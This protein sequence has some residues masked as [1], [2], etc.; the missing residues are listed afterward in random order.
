MDVADMTGKTVIVTG[1]NSGIGLETDGAGIA[2]K[3]F[4]D[5][6][7]ISAADAPPDGPGD[8]RQAAARIVGAFRA[9]GKRVY[10]ADFTTPDVRQL[11]LSVQRVWSPDLIA[12]PLPSAPPL[13]HPRF[14][15]YGG[16]ARDDPHPY[17]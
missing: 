5:C 9:A 16:V 4:A 10:H 8:P 11:G 17:P 14:A 2:E 12:L 3:R 7:E 13:A 6:Q 15:A 1:G